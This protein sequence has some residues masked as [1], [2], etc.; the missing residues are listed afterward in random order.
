MR[1]LPAHCFITRRACWIW[2]RPLHEE[3]FDRRT[4]LF[5][6]LCLRRVKEINAMLA[7]ISP[8]T[9]GQAA[10]T[11]TVLGPALDAAECPEFA[12]EISA[13]GRGA[14][15]FH[16]IAS[17]GTVAAREFASWLCLEKKCAKVGAWCFQ[18][19]AMKSGNC[20]AHTE[21]FLTPIVLFAPSSQ[22]GS[23]LFI[24]LPLICIHRLFF[25]IC[26]AIV[27]TRS[28]CAKVSTVVRFPS[29]SFCVC[30]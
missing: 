28:Y 20:G 26:R 3:S 16:A 25:G 19:V 5:P 18:G 27:E 29:S 6:P 30:R 22:G 1:G 9:S 14:L 17:S 21:N 12:S 7:I 8:A 13:T 23:R 24:H 11:D 10:L 15:I 2:R 4:T